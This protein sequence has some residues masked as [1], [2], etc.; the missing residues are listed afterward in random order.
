MVEDPV[1]IINGSVLRGASRTEIVRAA[2][3]CARAVVHLAPS[4]NRDALVAVKAAERWARYPCDKT[5][6]AALKA[7]QDCL[8]MRNVAEDWRDG[9][10]PT[11][12]W[13]V[14]SAIMA[15]LSCY[16]DKN[17]YEFTAVLSVEYS[18]KAA[19]G[20]DIDLATVVTSVLL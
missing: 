12:A 4:G 16:T 7:G 5:E 17:L 9:G 15:V 2:A 10:D 13:A 3:A 1:E 11:E 20:R 8:K 19:A 14:L 6:I 18:A